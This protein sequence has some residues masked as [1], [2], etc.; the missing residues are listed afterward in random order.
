MHREENIMTIGDKLSKL[1]KQNNYTQEQL[2][3][4][5]GVSRQAISKWESNA[6]YPETEKLIQLSNMYHCSL[7]YLLRD[8][9]ESDDFNKNGKSVNLEKHFYYEK[10]SEK[11]IKGIPLWHINIGSGRT[12]KGIFAVGLRAKGIVS[13]GIASMGVVSVGIASIGVLSIGIAT[14]GIVAAG[15]I[16]VGVIAMGAI[17]VGILAMGAIAVGAFSGGALAIG[18]YVAAGDYARGAIA[19]GQSEAYGR[20]YQKVGELS[21]EEYGQV[22][23]LITKEV[24]SYLSWAGNIMKA[25]LK[26]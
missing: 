18:N 2:A 9:M 1:R 10:T 20:I 14:L 23:D 12:A 21:S 19:I 11:K 6:S 4:I 25:F 5:L 17:C 13:V 22:C 7:D 3:D 16:A 8:E 26:F 24:P 15:N